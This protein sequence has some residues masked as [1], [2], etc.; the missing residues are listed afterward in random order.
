MLQETV[1]NLISFVLENYGPATAMFSTLLWVTIKQ[2][3]R[4]EKRIKELETD[5]DQQY[6]I[7]LQLHKDMISEYVD[8]VKN[9]TKVLSDLTAAI[10]AIKETLDRLERKT[11]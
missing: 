1:T 9:K 2:G 4:H 11:E 7:A 5:K 6:K 8:L 10:N 3:K